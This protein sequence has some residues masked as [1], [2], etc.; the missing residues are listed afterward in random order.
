VHEVVV[1][2]WRHLDSDE[3][4]GSERL[5]AWY[6]PADGRAR[7]L[8]DE[9]G[10]RVDVVVPAHGTLQLR[11]SDVGPKWTENPDPGFRRKNQTDFLHEFRRAYETGQLEE[12]GSRQFDG[13]EAIAY[14][15]KAPDGVDEVT[16]YVDPETAI[17]LGSTELFAHRRS[18]SNG[19]DPDFRG[20]L[21][22]R[23]LAQ[24]ERLPA[25]PESLRLLDAPTDELEPS[26][27][28]REI[29]KQP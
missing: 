27:V 14:R 1:T 9:A 19:H 4:L 15:V 3:P 8:Y 7:R 12:I 23:R 6:H 29:S 21:V 2:E 20:Q 5:E 10:G 28:W 11:G 13:R 18:A 16:W 17:P 25:T 22:T 24:Y 26:A